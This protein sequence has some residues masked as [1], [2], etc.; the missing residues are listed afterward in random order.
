MS[1]TIIEKRCRRRIEIDQDVYHTSL[2]AVKIA[3]SDHGRSKGH[4]LRMQPV[5]SGHEYYEMARP[6]L[7]S[8]VARTV[9]VK[10]P[11]LTS[12][13]YAGETALSI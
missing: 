6:Y 1:E 10:A 4:G 5:S 13:I 2:G 7:I 11:T 3:P 8:P 9:T 12:K